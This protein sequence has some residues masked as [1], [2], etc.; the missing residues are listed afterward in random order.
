MVLNNIFNRRMHGMGTLRRLRGMGTLRAIKD[1]PDG[2]KS[3]A[4]HGNP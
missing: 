1:I 4:W 2:P 3:D